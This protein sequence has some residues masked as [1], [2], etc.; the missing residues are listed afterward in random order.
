MRIISDIGDALQRRLW[1]LGLFLPALLSGGSEG[2]S[3]GYPDRGEAAE[4]FLLEWRGERPHPAA[5][6][7]GPQSLALAARKGAL[8]LVELRRTR[9]DSGWQLEQEVH[10]PFEGIRLLA[11]ECLNPRSPRLVWREI[12]TAAGR[13]VFAEWTADSEELR[14]LE[15]G[16]DGSLRETCSTSRGAVMPHYLLELAR[17]GQ[18]TGGT[19]EVFDPLARDLA[20]WSVSTAYVREEEGGERDGYPRRV[21][22]RRE[23]GTLAGRY[24][25]RGARL[26]SFQWQEGE[27]RARAIPQA[28]YDE[29]RGRWGL[30]P[31]ADPDQDRGDGVKDL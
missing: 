6:W 8:G 22:F 31:T 4:F 23:D 14:A 27:V 17:C 28:E 3:G 19:F 20:R 13:T 1:L 11:V 7:T 26:L 24:V 18:I 5:A 2:S 29:L 16:V 9:V 12:S 21:E 15:W 30:D 25:F 10:Y